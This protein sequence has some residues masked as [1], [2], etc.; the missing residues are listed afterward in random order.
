MTQQDKTRPTRRRKTRKPKRSKWTLQKILERVKSFGFKTRVAWYRGDQ[1][2]YDAAWRQGYVD[3]V[4]KECEFVSKYTR[5]N[6]L[7]MF[8][9]N[10]PVD[11]L[12]GVCLSEGGAFALD[13]KPGFFKVG[14]T[15]KDTNNRRIEYTCT[16]LKVKP[17]SVIFFELRHLDGDEIRTEQTLKYFERLVV[18]DY[19]C[20]G[21][22]RFRGP[23]Y[24]EICRRGFLA[25][26]AT[27]RGSLKEYKV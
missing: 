11:M 5:S 8:E 12:S 3:I 26:C 24:T 18:N 22:H 7:Y 4:A 19:S 23:G 13:G 15:S 16:K 27:L 1:K 17:T 21:D 2:S 6:L 10:M 9:F 20:P 25:S 14:L